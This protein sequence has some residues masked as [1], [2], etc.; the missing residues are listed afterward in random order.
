MPGILRY[1]RLTSGF[2]PDV[3]EAVSGVAVVAEIKRASPSK[4]DIAAG[5]VAGEQGAKYAQAGCSAI[6]VLTEPTWFKVSFGI[7]CGY[8]MV[9]GC[10]LWVWS[11]LG[12]AS[13]L[14]THWPLPAG[15]ARRHA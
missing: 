14:T 9:L 13:S 5:I 12:D 2:E 7:R 6:S 4:G 8:G 1:L 11:S 10:C 3:Q 15:D